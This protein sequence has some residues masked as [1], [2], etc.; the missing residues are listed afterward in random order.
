M[1]RIV[2]LGTGTDVGKTH[3][4]VALTRCLAHRVPT[5]AVKPVETGTHP[6]WP[7]CEATR[8]PDPASDA[9]ALEAASGRALEHPHPLYAFAQP[10]SPHRAA[11]DANVVID[12]PTIV[13]WIEAIETRATARS[14]T[15][16]LVLIETAG[17]AF[18][19]LHPGI[20]N[21][22]LA[23]AL[24]PAL[25]LL[26]APDSLGV[27]H[28]ITATATALATVPTPAPWVLLTG[29]RPPDGSTGTHAAEL[30]VL[31]GPPVLG[32]L[33]RG[34]HSFEPA[35]VERLLDL[36]YPTCT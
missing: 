17:G 25:I 21:A 33:S 19:P 31:G 23:H 29:A 9:A 22:H 20:T 13:S 4:T 28:D 27:L 14:G 24:E 8:P 2:I 35:V 1:P 18:S 11:R 32:T 26:V 3:V 16:P 7:T 5:L 15:L 12:V 6:S 34:A 36:V 30:P 10:V